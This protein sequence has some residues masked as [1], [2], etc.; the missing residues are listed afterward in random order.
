MAK[1][2]PPEELDSFDFSTPKP[3]N[4]RRKQLTKKGQRKVR[5]AKE[6][7][8]SPQERAEAARDAGL[9]V[10]IGQLKGAGVI[11]EIPSEFGS[12]IM[13]MIDEDALYTA[14]RTHMSFDELATIF[15]VS[16]PVLQTHPYYLP[17]IERARA[18]AKMKLRSAQM[19]NA[20][21]NDNPTMQI[22]LG[23]N[24]LGQKD[25]ARVENT[26]VDGK[27]QEHVITRRVTAAIPDNG[28]DTP[29]QPPPA[30]D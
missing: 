6:A 30:E 14:A 3:V 15:G 26:G 17:I 10:V 24:L 1:S 25:V 20:V 27:P 11:A 28:R 22:F 21:E 19:R 29:S 4:P 23:K 9:M 12:K 5:K 18:E 13:I 16:A 8:M 7:T 2:R